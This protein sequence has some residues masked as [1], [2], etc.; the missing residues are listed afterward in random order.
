MGSFLRRIIMLSGLG[1]I[2]MITSEP[3]KNG[4]GGKTE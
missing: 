1:A 2:R 4:Q 3:E